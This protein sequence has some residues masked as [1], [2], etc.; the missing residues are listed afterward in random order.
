VAGSGNNT[1][2]KASGTLRRGVRESLISFDQP[3]RD[4]TRF[5]DDQHFGVI[6]LV[7]T[8]D[9]TGDGTWGSAFVR[10]DGV[11][12]DPTGTGAVVSKPGSTDDRIAGRLERLRGWFGAGCG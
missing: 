5:R 2:A 4:G 7:L 9:D 6:R 10:T 3:S 8:G 11:T 1:G 12:A